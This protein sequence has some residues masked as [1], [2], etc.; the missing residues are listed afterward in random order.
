M[1]VEQQRYLEECRKILDKKQLEVIAMA[2]DYG[3]Q[4]SEIRKVVQGNLSADCMHEIVSGLMNGVDGDAVDFLCE[5]E[6]NKYQIREIVEGLTG[7]LAFEQVKTYAAR[8]MSA[9]H[10]RKMRM[11]MEE[12]ARSGTGK[13]G[14]GDGVQEYM[15]GLVEVMETSIRQFQESNERFDAL[16]SLVKEHVVEEKNRELQELYENLRHKDQTIQ[17]L[18]EKLADQERKIGKLEALLRLEQK[19][20][21]GVGKPDR[22]TKEPGRAGNP[23]QGTEHQ[24]GK[25]QAERA[26]EGNHAAWPL[27]M[28]PEEKEALDI[29][30]IE[31]GQSLKKRMVSGLAFWNRGK[32]KDVLGRIME[33]DLS[34]QQLEEVCRCLESGL[35][36]AEIGSLIE[37]DPSPEKIQKMREILLLMRKRKGGEGIV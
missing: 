15:K 12:L 32:K 23:A 19:E 9:S 20:P 17:Q 1:T 34:P 10:M 14:E 26:A 35:T 30:G 24:N 2:L 27:G 31:G 8:E 13:E 37:N 16:S 4:I 25:G 33:A 36:D 5:N 28:E 6:F 11:Q 18:Q 21:G 3:L 7:G 22:G 29:S